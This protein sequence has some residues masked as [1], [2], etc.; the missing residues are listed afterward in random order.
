[1][2]Y[3]RKYNDREIEHLIFFE[4]FTEALQ[5]NDIEKL[6]LIPPGQF[7]YAFYDIYKNKCDNLNYKK[8]CLQC[9][10]KCGLRYLKFKCEKERYEW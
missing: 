8:V 7:T 4:T 3:E 2:K 9:K 10:D 1:M 6:K 5:K